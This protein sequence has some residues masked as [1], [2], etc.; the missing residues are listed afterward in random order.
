MDYIQPIEAPTGRGRVNWV[1]SR[2]SV[3]ILTKVAVVLLFA[4]AG[5]IVW[6]GI[7]GLIISKERAEKSELKNSIKAAYQAQLNLI[8][9]VNKERV[10]AEAAYL[11]AL[12]K[13]IKSAK[14]RQK[15]VTKI[16]ERAVNAD[17]SF[18]SCKRSD[19]LHRERLQQLSDIRKAIP[20]RVQ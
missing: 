18:A 2:L 9:A 16:I 17:P 10:A 20:D 7:Q 8:L 11:D 15:T 14:P 3:P 4:L 19:E 5:C 6:I 13:A 1:V 12:D